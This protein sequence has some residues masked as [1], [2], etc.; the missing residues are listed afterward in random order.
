MKSSTS[1][2]PD[3]ISPASIS[4]AGLSHRSRPSLS[5]EDLQKEE[6]RRK[7]G[8]YK[9]R[10]YYKQLFV[11][12]S[13]LDDCIYRYMNS[14]NQNENCVTCHVSRVMCHVSFVTCHVS[15]VMCHV[16]CCCPYLCP[17]LVLSG[18]SQ[19]SMLELRSLSLLWCHNVLYC[20]VLYCTVLYCTV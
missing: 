1:P 16:S 20:T 11:C 8:I 2:L 12:V 13:L 10:E 18:R 3:L 4:R 7:L 5:E 15:R 6:N 17:G 9:A 19:V 14:R